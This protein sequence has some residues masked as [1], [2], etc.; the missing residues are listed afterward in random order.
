MLISTPVS[1][2]IFATFYVI[3]LTYLCD[4]LVS[5]W[6]VLSLFH[7]RSS[8]RGLSGI[9]AF[10]FC[11]VSLALTLSGIQATSLSQ[12]TWHLLNV[13]TYGPV[14]I[15]M[16][17]HHK[18]INLLNSWATPRS[19]GDPPNSVYC[20]LLYPVLPVSECMLS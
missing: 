12:T 1:E 18:C 13:S 9:R 3:T 6:D 4:L 15:V 11:F 16:Q 10:V 14:S 17:T 7:S 8:L 19:A 20:K 2:F 5:R